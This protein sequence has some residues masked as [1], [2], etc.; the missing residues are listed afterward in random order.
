MSEKTTQI[1]LLSDAER[2]EDL[3]HILSLPADFE[4]PCA[5]WPPEPA[6][7]GRRGGAVAWLLDNAPIALV[8]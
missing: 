1:K 7:Y 5:E 4:A 3:H 6:A 2:Y 8:R